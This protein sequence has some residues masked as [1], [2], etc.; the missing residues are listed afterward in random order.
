VD[1]ATRTFWSRGAAD[2]VTLVESD[3]AVAAR[4]L[5]DRVRAMVAAHDGG[6]RR[7]GVRPSGNPAFSEALFVELIR[8]GQHARAFALLAPD[9]QQPLGQRRALRR[10]PPRGL[11]PADWR[12]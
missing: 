2:P 3:T 5:R 8:G 10:R 11:P 7:G 4:P 1:A 12:A 6:Q 9:C